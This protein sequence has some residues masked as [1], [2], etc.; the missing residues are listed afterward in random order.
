MTTPQQPGWYD[1]P[2]APNAQ[3]YWDGQDWTPQRR[4][5]PMAAPASPP[6]QPQ[7]PAPASPPPSPPSHLPPPPPADAPPPPPTE[8][9]PRHAP[10]KKF[11]VSKVAL[12]LAFLALVLAI[13][14]VVA[15]RVKL[16]SFVP[17]IG[18]VAAIGVI[19]AFFAIRSHQS[20]A[21]KAMVVTAV[22]L[23]VAAAIPASLKVVYPVYNHFFPQKSAQTSHPATADSGSGPGAP[24]NEPGAEAPSGGA[25]RAPAAGA[26]AASPAGANSGIL[27]MN[28][29]LH[30]Y[31][32]IDPSSGKYSEAVT[33]HLPSTGPT[34]GSSYQ[35]STHPELAASPDLT[36]FAVDLTA[37]TQ[38][39]AGWVDSSGK[40]T[41]VT[42]PAAGGAFAGN[43]PSYS[44]IGF[45][46][47]GNY[48]YEKNSQGAMYTEV[49][50]V[51]SGSTSNARQVS[52]NPHANNHVVTL[53]ADGSVLFGC[54]NMVGSW[55]DANTRVLAIAPG[56][57]IAKVAV[58]SHGPGGCPVTGTQVPLLP[59]S[60]TAL[61]H[62][63]VANSDGT[64]VAFLYDDPDRVNHNFET[65]YTIATDGNSQPTMVNLSESDAKKLTGATF[66]RWS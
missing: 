29:Y 7:Q 17:G 46:K 59:S 23:V 56:T 33:F 5:N 22:V 20:V 9:Q 61:V 50:E 26:P 11:R 4:R 24:S 6:T 57:Q 37:L 12:V 8:V 16:G 14:A 41:S 1:D 44:A 43:P 30:K 3:R 28:S 19:A 27:V 2:N 13:A 62:D 40:F 47:A 64:K 63:P 39:A 21:R 54:E 18:L 38:S 32:F 36:K 48:Y 42:T 55:L 25:P 66:L 45:D 58:T 51:P 34:P 52:L 31:G 35:F 53:N 10:R 60:N 65:V 49:Y 15:G